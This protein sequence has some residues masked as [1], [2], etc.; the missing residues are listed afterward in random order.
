MMRDQ[1]YF[2]TPEQ[3]MR[4]IEL[5][6][7]DGSGSM[8]WGLE[9]ESSEKFFRS[10]NVQARLAWNIPLTTHTYL[11]EGYFCEKEL[12]PWKVSFVCPEALELYMQG[13]SV[14]NQLG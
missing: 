8:L 7:C 9:T 12:N 13:N 1:F 5:Y 3:R 11:I 6:C 14:S 4:A 10:W 2:G